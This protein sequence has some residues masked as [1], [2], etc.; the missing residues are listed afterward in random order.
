MAYQY[1]RE[2]LNNDEAERILPAYQLD[3]VLLFF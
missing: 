3:I 2:S 1:K